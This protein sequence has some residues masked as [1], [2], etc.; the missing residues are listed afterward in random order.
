M[1]CSAA[2]VQ[3]VSSIQNALTGANYSVWIDEAGIRAGAKWR[4]AI[5]NGIE[6]SMHVVN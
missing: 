3:A 5:A 6:V 4:D 1:I 2:F